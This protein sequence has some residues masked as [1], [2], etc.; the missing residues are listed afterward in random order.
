MDWFKSLIFGLGSGISEFLPISSSAH[1]SILSKLFGQTFPDP[2]RNIVIRIALIF[3]VLTAGRNLIDQLRRQRHAAH[4][5]RNLGAAR[6][7]LELRFLKNAVPS[8]FITYLFLQFGVKFESTL[9]WV[10][11]FS[12]V[13]GILLFAQGRMMQ[14]NKDEQLMSVLDSISVGFV[15]A[16]SAFS[17]ISRVCVMLT[18][19]ILRGVSRIKAIN[20]VILL[21]VPALVLSI[22]L[23]LL[24][25]FSASGGI[26]FSGGFL[27]YVFSGL[28]AYLAGCLGISLLKTM[29]GE[30]G[31]AGFAFYSW[32]V[33]L[34]SFLLYLTVV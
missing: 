27:G 7:A 8:Y 31:P 28:G 33:S 9:A 13:N 4:N 29:T 5:R 23:D 32:G 34:F 25:V 26:A 22:A 10:S 3:A 17:G 24:S 30:K 6:G 20:W 15:G 18:F 19:L 14:G 11:L 2:V 12:L 16:F 1:Q 21:S